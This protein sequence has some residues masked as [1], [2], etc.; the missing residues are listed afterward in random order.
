[1]ITNERQYRITRNQAKNF[2]RG[3]REF[4]VNKDKS[5]DVPAKLLQ[6]EREAMVSVL[7]GLREE[8]EEYERLKSSKISSIST[9]SFDEL[10]IGLIKARISGGLTQR[11]LAERLGLKEQQIQRYETE[12]YASASF[13]RLGEVANALEIQI[14]NEILLPASMASFHDIVKKTK[15]AGVNR[16][17]VISRLLSSADAAK[18]NGEVNDGQN[19]HVLV[20]RLAEVLKHVFGWSLGGILR[21]EPVSLPSV[22]TRTA[23]FS[24][25][26][27]PQLPE[28]VAFTTYAHHLAHVALEG[29]E[30][31]KQAAIPT[32]PR[33][34]RQVILERGSKTDDLRGVLE[35]V[36]D[37]GVVVLPLRG[38][39]TFLGACW[40]SHGRIVI[41]LKPTTQFESRWIFDLLHELFHAAQNREHLHCGMIEST[42]TS[43]ERRESDEEHA[44]SQYAADIMLDCKA[45]ELT[46][47][48]V[49]STRGHPDRLKGEVNKVSRESHVDPNALANYLIYS[50]KLEGH[51]WW[52]TTPPLKQTSDP[53]Q[54]ARDVFYDRFQFQIANE[55]DR[56]LL[57]RALN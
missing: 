29:M 13:K 45:E 6:A 57:N 27:S 43:S 30:H 12:R 44:A 50:Q 33:E 55:L 31:Q 42:P 35:T 19:E 2:E 40:R 26:Q 17:F 36:W 24:I 18:A 8:I 51:D 28:L 39:G 22:A 25:P 7:S 41:V 3:I 1:M 20:S 9:S 49:V 21:D 4:D 56:S 16:D 10:A 54:T 48:C 34:M 53:W 23:R 5:S 14:K 37:L 46:Q 11:A 38:K 32:K 52:G 47:R 15:L